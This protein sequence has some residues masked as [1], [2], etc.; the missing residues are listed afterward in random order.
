VT[1]SDKN[2][3]HLLVELI[4]SIQVTRLYKEVPFYVI[5]G[6]LTEQQIQ[7]LTKN[8]IQIIQANFQLNISAFITLTDIQSHPP[9][10]LI[11]VVNKAF[12]PKLIPGFQYYFWI[13]SNYWI[14]DEQA[15]DAY[16]ALAERQQIAHSHSLQ[17]DF[18]IHILE[19]MNQKYTSL[20]PKALYDECRN[21]LHG[22]DAVFCAHRSFFIEAES[23]IKEFT[24]DGIYFYY[25][26]ELIQTLYMKRH[27][28]DKYVDTKWYA[29]TNHTELEGGFKPIHRSDNGQILYTMHNLLHPVGIIRPISKIDFQDSISIFDPNLNQIVGQ[30][31]G[32][33]RFALR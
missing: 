20:I 19:R 31:Q 23:M 22:C 26:F 27:A 3:F 10:H 18:S 24:K 29:H 5:D 16:L 12:L 4:A 13:N 1:S 9:K 30:I 11:G 2:Y 17:R 28:L 7:F 8:G 21:R 32:S 33:T 14:Q 15:I 6:G 25:L